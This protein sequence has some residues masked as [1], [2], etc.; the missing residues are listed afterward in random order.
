V[1]LTWS[2]TPWQP[3]QLGCVERSSPEAAKRCAGGAGLDGDEARR[4][5]IAAAVASWSSP[6]SHC[7]TRIRFYPL[8]A[9]QGSRFSTRS[10]GTASRQG[11]KA[12]ATIFMAH[13]PGSGC[14][15]LCAVIR[16]S[17]LRDVVPQRGTY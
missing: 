5:T 7:R 16:T 14:R 15:T 2:F 12:G 17:S 13:F 1:T 11:S 6:S 4:A 10:V 8:D 9:T 3:L